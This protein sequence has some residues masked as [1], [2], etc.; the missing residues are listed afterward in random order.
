MWKTKFP[1]K[2]S[3]SLVSLQ[4]FM[5]GLSVTKRVQRTCPYVFDNYPKLL[6]SMFE[7][8]G[9]SSSFVLFIVPRWKNLGSYMFLGF[10]SH[11]YF[12]WALK[13]KVSSCYMV[14]VEKKSYS[15]VVQ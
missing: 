1:R 14:M 6:C 10:D 9:V 8:K 2:V 5:E 7:S 3:I 4:L 15:I 12:T 13:M 11:R